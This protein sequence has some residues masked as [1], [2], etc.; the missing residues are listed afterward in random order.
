MLELLVLAGFFFSTLLVTH[1]VVQYHQA[2]GFTGIDVNKPRKPKI[3]EGT[4][5]ALIPS[6]LAGALLLA[7]WNPSER[8]AILSWGALVSAFTLIGYWDDT[9]KKKLGWI[10]RTLPVMAVS[11]A[12]AWM[13][14][15]SM[16][17]VLP[18]AL[19]VAG[20]PALTNTF[21][22]LNGWATGSTAVIALFSV[23]V[24]WNTPYYFLSLITL[25][26]IAG[27]AVLNQFPARMFPG[28]AGTLGMGSALA[29]MIAL[30]QEHGLYVLF[31][32]FY[33][34]HLADVLGFKFLSNAKDMSQKKFAPYSVLKDGRI[35]VPEYADG[36]IRY[37]FAKAIL[38]MLGPLHERHVVWIIWGVVVLNGLFWLAVTGRF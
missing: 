12:F 35:A 7:A 1:A 9:S 11:I 21:E 3:P 32:L 22:G 23:Y 28:D 36:R 34:P 19:F 33:L 15:P 8:I 24:L 26:I 27:F 13:H 37:D 38:R 18:L 6:A 14:A 2:K 17:W 30:T 29:G 25:A 5:I 4:G 31:T 16:E 10:P 20:I